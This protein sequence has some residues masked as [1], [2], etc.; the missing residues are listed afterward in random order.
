MGSKSKAYNKKTVQAFQT[1]N[2]EEYDG[3]AESGPVPPVPS[4]DGTNYRR[5][6]RLARESE[7]IDRTIEPVEIAMLFHFIG[8]LGIRV[9]F[10]E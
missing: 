8:K 5:M 6:R 7:R 10:E 9:R 3:D 2:E 1:M 4:L